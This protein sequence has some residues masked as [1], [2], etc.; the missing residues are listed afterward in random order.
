[1]NRRTQNDLLCSFRCFSAARENMNPMR[2]TENL[3]EPGGYLTVISTLSM[4][5]TA[6][7]VVFLMSSIV[8]A[9]RNKNGKTTAEYDQQDTDYH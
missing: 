7:T 8:A 1:M 4:T 3:I 5:T 2:L 9:L 6:T